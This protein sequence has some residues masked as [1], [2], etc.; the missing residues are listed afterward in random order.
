MRLRLGES[1]RD[2]GPIRS[3]DHYKLDR[4]IAVIVLVRRAREADLLRLQNALRFP[5]PLDER[6]PDLMRAGGHRDAHFDAGVRS[7]HVDFV[8]RR[9]LR[10]AREAFGRSHPLGLVRP[11]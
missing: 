5:P 1:P 3:P 8:L 6:S 4:R 9:S 10:I 7:V 11:P 2:T